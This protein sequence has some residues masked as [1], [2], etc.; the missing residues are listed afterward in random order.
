[1]LPVVQSFE[2][3]MAD[4]CHHLLLACAGVKAPLDE[5][6]RDSGDEKRGGIS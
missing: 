1:M 5:Q 2:D 4:S 6:E 3:R